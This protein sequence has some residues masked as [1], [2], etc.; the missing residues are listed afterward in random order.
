MNQIDEIIVDR[1][2]L[3]ITNYTHFKNKYIIAK[4]EFDQN[5]KSIKRLK[6]CYP[7]N[8]VVKSLK[9]F[10]SRIQADQ[11]TFK[12]NKKYKSRGIQKNYAFLRYSQIDTN[13]KNIKSSENFELFYSE[14]KQQYDSQS[15]AFLQKDLDWIQKN[16]LINSNDKVCYYCGISESILKVLY[17]DRTN[18]CKTKRNRG[19]WFELDR[20]DARQGNNI[21]NDNNIVLACYFCNNHKSDVVSCDDMR[22][23]FGK[24]M[25]QFLLSQYN[26]VK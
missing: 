6:E 25:F 21:Y 1:V 22:F 18:T 17:A 11:K 3:K 13:G 19:S 24:A 20:K 15:K 7:D 5:F 26:L 16:A 8:L 9:L 10:Q 4:L 23:Y 12:W 14:L 2:V